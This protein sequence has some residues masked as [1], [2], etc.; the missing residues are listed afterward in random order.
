MFYVLRVLILGL[1]AAAGQHQ[2][3]ATSLAGGTL[4]AAAMFNG[5]GV[6]TPVAAASVAPPAAGGYASS[7]HALGG[8]HFSLP[9]AAAP[10]AHSVNPAIEATLS[11]A[12][13]G[14]AQYTGIRLVPASCYR[15]PPDDRRAP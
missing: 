5:S 1:Q 9:T 10:Q 13:S 15:T 7:H 6:G 14:I 2:T 8:G 3:T 4:N 12:Y 11:Q